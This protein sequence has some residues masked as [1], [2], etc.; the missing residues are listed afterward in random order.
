MGQVCAGEGLINL[1]NRAAF[2]ASLIATYATRV[3]PSLIPWSHRC[4][5]GNDG[6]LTL[7][8]SI[9]QGNHDPME[10]IEPSLAFVESCRAALREFEDEGISGFWELFGPLDDAEA[11]I[12]RIKQYQ[13]VA[14]LPIGLV[15]AS[16]FW[17][18]DSGEFIGH[19][20]VRH[21]LNTAL[22]RRGG[23]I[24]YAIRPSKQGQGYGSQILKCVLPCVRTLGIRKALV[25]C[26]KDNLASRKIIE[27]NGGVLADEIEVNGKVGLRFWI[28]L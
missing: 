25:T 10:L 18:V 13:H 9:H 23:H 14:G 4:T 1:R 21:C 16:V 28:Q 15:P 3:G 19:V 8:V 24:G 17:L 12:Q 22:E 2:P 6:V 26:D 27:K 7:S 11:Y 5:L 20:S